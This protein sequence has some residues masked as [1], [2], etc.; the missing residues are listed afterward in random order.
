MGNFYVN[1]TLRGVSQRGV[2][3]ALAGRAC[4]VTP[5]ANDT[6]VVFDE[7]S[8]GQNTRVIASL[9][10]ELSGKLRCPVLAVLNHD[11]DILWYQLYTDG[12]LQDEYDSSPGYFDSDAEPS[13]PAGGN[14]AKLCAAFGASDPREVERVLRKSFFDGDGYAFAFERH[15]DLVDALGISPF[16]VGT[17]YASFESDELPEGLAPEDVIRTA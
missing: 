2:A 9:A 15:N 7:Q 11:D 12:T 6:V 16:A 17:A 1:Y 8:D 3:D 14:A 4:I 5:P 13:R 10:A